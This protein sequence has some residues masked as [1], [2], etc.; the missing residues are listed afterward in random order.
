MRAALTTGQEFVGRAGKVDAHRVVKG[1][2]IAAQAGKGG[3]GAPLAKASWQDRSA[4]PS[5]A[6]FQTVMTSLLPFDNS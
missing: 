1:S 4:S 3:V 6:G 2:I 5:S